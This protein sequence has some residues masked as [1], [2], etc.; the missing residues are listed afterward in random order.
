MNSFWI[1]G[2]AVVL[3]TISYA[4][5]EA[6][7]TGNKFRSCVTKHQ[8]QIALN[9]GG[10]LFCIG[11]VGTTDVVWQQILWAL[12]G[13]GFLIQIVVELFPKGGK[14]ENQRR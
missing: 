2:C 1:L 7:A 13:I 6:S 12:L 11:L 4:S 5:W 14:S 3:A 10:L 8:S 9:L